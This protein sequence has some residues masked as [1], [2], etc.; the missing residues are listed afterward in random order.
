M[1][2]DNITH[3]R[4]LTKAN[5]AWSKALEIQIA[6]LGIS[7]P[8]EIRTEYDKIKQEIHALEQAIARSRATRRA[9]AARKRATPPAPDTSTSPYERAHERI[10]CPYPG[11]CVIVLSDITNEIESGDH[12]SVDRTIWRNDLGEQ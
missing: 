8:P 4:T 5:Q 11:G 1:G 3:L 9:P 2:T 6:T 7:C 10:A 12:Q